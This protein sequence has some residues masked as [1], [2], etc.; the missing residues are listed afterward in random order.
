MPDEPLIFVEVTLVRDMAGN[1]QAL[2]DEHATPLD[3]ARADTAIFYSISN[4][5]RGLAGISFGNFLIKRVVE[6][7]AKE[8]PN[9]E[10][11]ATLS[12]I[13]GFRAW[14]DPLLARGTEDLFT[15]GDAQ[16]LMR[17]AG[18]QSGAE[19][20]A[21]LLAEGWPE[22]PEA[23]RAMEAPLRRLCARYLVKESRNGRRSIP[24]PA[25]TWP[26]GPGSNGSTPWRIRRRRACAKR[27]A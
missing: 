22:R 20:L 12:P 17:L 24:W 25:F 9:L 16:A 26:T 14:L 3:P 21:R 19:S 15:P 23:A 4:A 8:L 7:L 2:P 27:R 13:P 6:V 5:Q 1:V 11:F 18:A 10:T